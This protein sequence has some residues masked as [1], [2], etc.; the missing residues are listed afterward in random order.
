MLRLVRITNF[1]LKA[2]LRTVT[3]SSVAFAVCFII[4]VRF[5]P[6]AR[7]PTLAAQA[8]MKQGKLVRLGSFSALRPHAKKRQL[9][10]NL[11]RAESRLAV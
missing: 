1:R 3:N 8:A 7:S 9:W 11:T 4:N 6:E 2:V 5:F 10:L